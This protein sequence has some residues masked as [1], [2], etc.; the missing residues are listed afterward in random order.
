MI[1]G[2]EV[3]SRAKSRKE[4]VRVECKDLMI[5]KRNFRSSES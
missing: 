1:K 2:L 3:F 5:R 4:Q